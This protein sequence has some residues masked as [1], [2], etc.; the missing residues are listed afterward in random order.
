M[1]IVVPSFTSCHECDKP[2][3]AT[4]LVRL[5]AGVSKDVCEA[6]DAPRDVPDADGARENSPH[7]D[8]RAKE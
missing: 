6:V 1:V 7:H 8:A 4:V 2:V 5:V 3:V